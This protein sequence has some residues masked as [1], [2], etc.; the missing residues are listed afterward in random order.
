MNAFLAWLWSVLAVL[1]SGADRVMRL[2]GT[3]QGITAVGSDYWVVSCI[4]PAGVFLLDRSNWTVSEYPGVFR[5]PHGTGLLGGEPLVC[6]SGADRLHVGLPGASRA[7]DLPGGPFAVTTTD[8]SGNGERT[9]VVTL[10]DSARVVLV[11]EFGMVVLAAV[12]GARVVAATDTDGD[13]SD[14]LLV[15]CCGTGLHLVVN[16]EDGGEPIVRRIG[17]LGDGVKAVVPLDMDDDGDPDAVGIACSEGGVCWW[18][19]P[20]P[21]GSEWSRHDLDPGVSGPKSIAVSGERILVA[22]LVSPSVLYGPGGIRLLPPGCTACAFD[23]D[24]AFVL[25]HRAGLIMEYST[26]AGLT[27]MR[28]LSL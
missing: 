12:Q 17:V 4:D 16:P 9:A 28:H 24:G 8:W 13:G 25:G 21:T 3:P 22:A 2:S 10:R 26:P 19:N 23:D 20:G 5:E 18:E 11:T 1:G 15:A 14:E 6:D 27:G 7:V